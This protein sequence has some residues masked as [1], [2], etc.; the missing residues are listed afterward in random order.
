MAATVAVEQRQVAEPLP[1][2]AVERQCATSGADTLASM[3]EQH[4][5]LG[6]TIAATAAACD[7]ENNLAETRARFEQEQRRLEEE[8][9]HA[10]GEATK[11]QCAMADVF[12]CYV[13]RVPG[14]AAAR[15]CASV[16]QWPSAVRQVLAAHA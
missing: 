5:L 16:P 12:T 10:A 4:R 9:R 14:S 6:A 13:L 11:R 1:A 7:A 3:R 8:R 15:Q 2:T